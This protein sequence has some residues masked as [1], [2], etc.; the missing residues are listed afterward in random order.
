[1]DFDA[2]TLWS[3]VFVI[4]A[5]MGLKYLPRWQAR[6]PFVGPEVLKALLDE[7]RDIVVLDV[8]TTGEV[9]VKGLVP[10]ATHVAMGD[11][12]ARLRAR[13]RELDTLKDQAIWVYCHREGRAARAARMLR[14]AGFTNVSVLQGGFIGWKRK[15]YPTERSTAASSP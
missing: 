12:Q 4:A 8:R 7:G 6:S 11:L 9:A 3:L 1:M 5:A 10:G 15:G 13:D 2:R 14:D